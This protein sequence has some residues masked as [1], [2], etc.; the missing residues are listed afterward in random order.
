MSAV[1]EEPLYRLRV[2]DTTGVCTWESRIHRANPD[3]TENR[4][5]SFATAPR[6]A[7]V[8]F[9]RLSWCSTYTIPFEA[10]REIGNSD[11]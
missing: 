7:S 11:P 3:L 4:S 1:D 9:S 5:R 10:R 6:L 2:T 8:C